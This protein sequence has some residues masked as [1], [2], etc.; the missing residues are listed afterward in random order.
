LE[1][2]GIVTAAELD[3]DT[4]ADRLRQEAIEIGGCVSGPIMV[5]AAARK[6]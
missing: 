3:L 5:S 1:A 6:P 4:L 2:L